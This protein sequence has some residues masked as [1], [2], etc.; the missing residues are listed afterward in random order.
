[1]DNEKKNE[2]KG[3]TR[4]EFAKSLVVGGAIG[5]IGMMGLYSYSPWRKKHFAKIVP[6]QIDIGE[7]KSIKI[8]NISET[9]W[10]DNKVLMGDIKGAGGLLVNQYEYNWPPFADVKGK[11]G[12]GSYEA[13]IKHIK[14]YLPNNLEKAWQFQMEN[15]VHPENAGGY[16][17][18]I[19]VEL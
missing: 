6:K 4:R 2:D 15:A 12:K 1:M 19:D 9:S 5:A 17:C 13:G 8:L 16:A 18:L 7:C 3:M 10:F 14:Q 11:L